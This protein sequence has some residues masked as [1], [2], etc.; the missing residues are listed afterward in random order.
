MAG[1]KL[2]SAEP[3]V[4][5]SGAA[6]VGAEQGVGQVVRVLLHQVSDEHLCPEELGVAAGAVSGAV[7]LVEELV[8]VGGEKVTLEAEQIAK[9]L[10]LR[11]S[12]ISRS[13]FF[14]V[15]VTFDKKKVNFPKHQLVCQV[16]NLLIHVG[17]KFVYFCPCAQRGQKRSRLRLEGEPEKLS[18]NSLAAAAASTLQLMPSLLLEEAAGI[19]RE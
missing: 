7:A 5:V 2:L 10:E 16:K 11:T 15:L 17:S 3:A 19:L 4:Y 18:Q 14:F 8:K 9:G 6:V 12:T 1:E 13:N